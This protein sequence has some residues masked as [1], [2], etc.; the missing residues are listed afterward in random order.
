MSKEGNWQTLIHIV[1]TIEG[2]QTPREG[3]C[4]LL[5]SSCMQF[6]P[7][8]FVGTTFLLW[9]ISRATTQSR[10]IKYSKTHLLPIYGAG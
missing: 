8:A 6:P 7:A 9:P 4:L 3:G 2:V 1:D 10:L 5:G